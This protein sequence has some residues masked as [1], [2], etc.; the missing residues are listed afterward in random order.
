MSFP[1]KQ[2]QQQAKETLLPKSSLVKQ[3]IWLGLPP[4]TDLR[5]NL[6][7]WLCHHRIEAPSVA[8][9]VNVFGEGQD[10]MCPHPLQENVCRPSLVKGLCW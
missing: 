1:Q 9:Q 5:G 7:R 6:G 10:L 4:G 2:H 8:N 3:C